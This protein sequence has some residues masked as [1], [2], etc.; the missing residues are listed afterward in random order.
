[1]THRISFT[2]S[3]IKI[4]YKFV[5]FCNNMSER[6]TKHCNRCL[7]TECEYN[8]ANFLESESD[9]KYNKN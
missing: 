5:G 7:E 6:N 1:M 2:V 8:K 9:V 4:N 3:N